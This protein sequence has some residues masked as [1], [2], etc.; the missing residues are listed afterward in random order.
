M[1]LWLF[2]IIVMHV[3]SFRSPFKCFDALLQVSKQCMAYRLASLLKG[4]G[5]EGHLDELAL[6]QVISTCE[7]IEYVYSAVWL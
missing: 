2:S 6:I 4:I 5:S 3:V 1:F 7:I